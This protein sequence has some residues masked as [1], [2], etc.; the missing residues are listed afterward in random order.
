M[1]DKHIPLIQ[2]ESTGN[3]FSGTDDFFES[4]DDLWSAA[5]RT[6]DAAQKTEPSTGKVHNFERCLKKYYLPNP[7]WVY[8]KFPHQL[9]GGQKQRVMIAMAISCNPSF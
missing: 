2:G 5:M 7:E 1:N 9:S 6:S 8:N 4:C 3:D